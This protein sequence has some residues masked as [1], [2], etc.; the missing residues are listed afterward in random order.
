MATVTV[1]G[2]GNMGGALARAFSAAL[3]DRLVHHASMVTLKGKSYRLRSRTDP[4]LPPT[5]AAG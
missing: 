1:L 3:I 4:A 2:L 5:R